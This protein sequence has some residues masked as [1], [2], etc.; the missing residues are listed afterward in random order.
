[1]QL[2]QLLLEV[3]GCVEVLLLSRHVRLLPSPAGLLA[4]L[5]EEAQRSSCKSSC[6][7]STPFCSLAASGAFFFYDTESWNDAGGETYLP[8]PRLK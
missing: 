6:S 1:M 5:P 8:E 3:V 7:H 4:A 2:L